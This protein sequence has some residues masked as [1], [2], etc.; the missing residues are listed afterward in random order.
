MSTRPVGWPLPAD[1]VGRCPPP[2]TLRGRLHPVLY[3]YY[4][5]YY[6]YYGR[7]RSP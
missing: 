3:Y 1:S 7:T 6:Y 2:T 5:Y 4:Y